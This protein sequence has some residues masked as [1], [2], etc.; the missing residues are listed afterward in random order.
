MV[1]QERL[2]FAQ[3]QHWNAN[4]HAVA[5]EVIARRDHDPRIQGQAE[6]ISQLRRAGVLR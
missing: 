4:G 5:A 3:D 1:V 6:L 2:T